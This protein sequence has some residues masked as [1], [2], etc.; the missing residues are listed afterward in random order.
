MKIINAL[1][2]ITIINYPLQKFKKALA[3]FRIKIKI[4]ASNEEYKIIVG[5]ADTNYPNWISTDYPALDITNPDSIK[6]YFDKDSIKAV[7]SEHVFEHLTLQQA[8]SSLLIIKEYLVSGGYLRIAIPDGYH[9]SQQYIDAVKPGGSGPGS[10]DHKV[11]YN[12]K[13]ICE[14]IKK[15]GFKV[16]L[17]EWFD[18]QGEFHFVDWLP[19]TGFIKRSSRF[20]PRNNI[21]KLNYTSLIVDAI[22]P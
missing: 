9:P 10:D 13:T 6:K 7:L 14:L 2:Q 18:H 15:S 22:K 21:N 19:E 8:E 12:H 1:K 17:L 3:T 11:L 5:A 20:D 16:K 4:G